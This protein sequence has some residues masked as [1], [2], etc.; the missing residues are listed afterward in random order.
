L[1]RGKRRF[2]ELSPFELARPT[3]SE[4]WKKKFLFGK[5]KKFPKKDKSCFFGKKVIV[6]GLARR[7]PGRQMSVC[8][9]G[10]VFCP[11]RGL[12]FLRKLR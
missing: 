4:L 9:G 1:L 10:V 5:E 3:F 11:K 8:F 2:R 12:S 6:H 7:Y